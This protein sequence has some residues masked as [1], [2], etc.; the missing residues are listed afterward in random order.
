MRIYILFWPLRI[1]YILNSE[2]CHLKR[3][4][5]Y[6]LDRSTLSQNLSCIKVVVD[7]SLFIGFF[8]KQNGFEA[9]SIKA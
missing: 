4:K 9:L 1:T 7:T 3:I 6:N 2:H 5:P 8:W